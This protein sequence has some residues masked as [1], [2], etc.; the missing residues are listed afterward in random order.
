MKAL[1]LTQPWATLV[2][3]GAKR[4][5]T[6]SW[7]TR[8]RGPLAIHAAKGL[9]RDCYELCFDE[10]YYRTLML[11]LRQNLAGHRDDDLVLREGLPRGFVLATCELV[12][13][14]RIT[15]ANAPGEP[16]RSFGA[17]SPGRFAWKLAEIRMLPV[18]I[19]AKGALSLWEWDGGPSQ[20]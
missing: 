8:Y 13:C 12:D 4:I 3:I 16:E 15:D 20:L 11:A 1:T 19:P 17:Y 7:S 5:E 6:R 2:A 14:F 18:P 10:P 9:P